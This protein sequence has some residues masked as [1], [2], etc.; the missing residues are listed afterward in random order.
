MTETKTILITGAAG[1]IGRATVNLFAEKGWRVIGVDRAPF[2]EGFPANGLFI[3]SDI[4]HADEIAAIFEKAHQFT[5][6]LEALVNNAAMQIAK[7]LVET[8]VEEWD[9]VMAANLRS[10]FPP[11][12][13]FRPP[14]TSP[15]T[16]PPRAA[17]S[18]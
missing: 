1:G 14:P 17:C 7:P 18:P 12:T 10:V 8:T 5:D 13:P 6:S 11:C 3:Q 16:P 15:P 2:G 4:S 9:A